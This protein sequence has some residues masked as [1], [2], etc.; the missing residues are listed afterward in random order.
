MVDIK[1]LLES[2]NIRLTEQQLK[3][4]KHVEGPALV[5]AV[6]GA[7][8]T[9]VIMGRIA[10]LILNHKVR[11]D[12][13]LAITFSKASALDM[14]NRF[15]KLYANEGL[16]SVSFSTIHAFGNWVVS[17]Y[18]KRFN[19]QT[20]LITAKEAYDAIKAS[21]NKSTGKF[22]TEDSL[23]GY[24]T[25]IS[26]IKNKKLNNEEIK[27]YAKTSKIEALV[28]VISGYE[29]F[30]D[31][32][33]LYD[34]DDMLLNA[35]RILK[36]NKVTLD[37][38][39]Q[40]YEHIIIDEGQD[41][42][43]LQYDIVSLLVS[44]KTNNKKNV[45]IVGDDDQ[46]IYGFRGVTSDV[47]LNIEDRFPGIIKYYM[48]NNFR[49]QE[50]IIDAANALIKNNE[51]RFKKTIKSTKTKEDKVKIINA[52]DIVAQN[53]YIL[54]NMDLNNK[55][56][57]I[58]YRN[59][60]SV[61]TLANALKRE[62]I[63]FYAGSYKPGFFNHWVTHDMFSIINLLNNEGDLKSFSKIYYKIETYLTKKIINDLERYK[64][65]YVSIFDFLIDNYHLNKYQVD[66]IKG[67][68]AAFKR[69][70][71][72]TP[73]KGLEHLM[74]HL[75]YYDYLDRKAEENNASSRGY[76]QIV[77]TIIE[78]ARDVEKYDEIKTKMKELSEVL[79]NSRT[80]TKAKLHLSTLHS[81]KGLE[82]DEVFII[83]ANDGVI[84]S[85]PENKMT[86]KE[87]KE[88]LEAERRLF[89]VGVTRAK[90]NLNIICTEH[91][92]E[93]IEEMR[94]SADSIQT[95]KI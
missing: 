6:P 47:I 64:D 79:N 12:K 16:G 94:E 80:N 10:N 92:S 38:L 66:T 35:I 41:T 72:M 59:N 9:T 71:N 33:R 43:L 24:V 82:F 55:S 89:F 7:G 3:A 23:E 69:A 25:A 58:L 83:N 73:Y 11:G 52:K 56:T 61:V 84:P 85:V 53:K 57:A 67:I 44:N 18:N 75:G 2:K 62:G 22:L 32:N 1:T 70:R 95:I 65:N 17:S 60:I 37:F 42:S 91:E 51:K 14:T 8:K 13:I 77:D 48:E 36:E 39:Q 5:L 87:A 63:E 31:A 54:K 15:Q 27:E 50:N 34:Y 86:K 40:K 46:N 90:N 30:K 81:S 29:T 4:T 93:F 68:R 28:D 45:Y 76:I 26:Y 20:R 78:I 19:I 74:I 49:S 88:A 21:Y